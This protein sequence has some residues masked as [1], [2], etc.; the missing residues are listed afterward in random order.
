MIALQIQYSLLERTIEDEL[1]PMA[2][3]LG[4]GVTP[5]S[6]L[7]NGILSGKYTRANAGN[8]EATIADGGHG[9]DIWPCHNPEHAPLGAVVVV[10]CTPPSKR[11]RW[12]PVGRPVR[13][14]KPLPIDREAPLDGVKSATAGRP[15]TES[16]AR[17][18][19]M[20]DKLDRSL[21]IETPKR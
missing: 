2:Q 19:A 20:L 7:R 17:I 5:W 13:I 9:T 12:R 11:P 16:F 6:P 3:E 21:H 10:V 8:P 14:S 1:M 4:L 18:A 15:K